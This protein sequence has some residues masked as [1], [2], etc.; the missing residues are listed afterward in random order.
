M[1]VKVFYLLASLSL[2]AC[3]GSSEPSD[4]NKAVP[5]QPP[6]IKSVDASDG[7]VSLEWQHPNNAVSFD[8][9][10]SFDEGFD[11]RNYASYSNSEWLRGVTSPFTFKPKNIKQPIFLRV[12]A[13][14]NDQE[15]SSEV[16]MTIARFQ[17][18]D[19]QVIDLH[20]NVTWAR[21]SAGMEWSSDLQTCV[22]EALALSFNEA[23]QYARSFNTN[24]R[25]PSLSELAEIVFCSSGN[26]Q[27]FLNE[28]SA[29]CIG[30]NDAPTIFYEAFPATQSRAYHTSTLWKHDGG[31]FYHSV[32][33]NN[34][35]FGSIFGR[36]PT[37]KSLRLILE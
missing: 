21:C 11:F 2:I 27:Y 19:N 36:E 3:G 1:N 18:S 6:V 14:S 30:E 32:F 16:F 4:N 17:A 24:A 28:N 13:I 20:T 37:G 8:V 22:G 29:S 9:Y 12:V 23:E 31:A 5:L 25:V 15:V 33:F 7:K 26:P 34:G 35:S 10:I